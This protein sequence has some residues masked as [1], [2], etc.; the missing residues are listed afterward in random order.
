MAV[1]VSPPSMKIAFARDAQG[2]PIFLNQYGY[3]LLENI[4]RRTGGGVD[5]VASAGD[6]ATA[7]QA[8][9]N[10]ALMAPVPVP[11]HRHAM[12]PVSVSYA[13]GG[14]L[15]PVSVGSCPTEALDPV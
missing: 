12:T 13:T 7:A 9:A 1:K 11:Y 3:T 8:S 10:A 14:G 2:K 4:F 5:S 6:T 15:A